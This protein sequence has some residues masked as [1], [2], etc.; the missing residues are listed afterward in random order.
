[1]HY[2]PHQNCWA[3]TFQKTIILLF[4]KLKENERTMALSC[5]T[6]WPH[7]LYSSWNSPGQNTGGGSLS[8]S[9]EDLP[10][11]GIEPRSHVMQVD[12]LPAEPQ[13]KAKN[14]EGD[15]LSLLQWIFFTNWAMREACNL[16][17]WFIPEE[18]G[19]IFWIKPLLSRLSHGQQV[20]N[21]AL[22]E[23]TLKEFVSI[24]LLPAYPMK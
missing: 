8:L 14:I 5:P 7:G 12:S 13:G 4:E 22:W 2:R 23:R 20:G 16:K 10:N 11:P 3:G 9:P 19:D 18:K 24:H 17:L 15:N 1:M 6:L 21:K